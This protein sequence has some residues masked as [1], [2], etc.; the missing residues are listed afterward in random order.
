VKAGE[1]TF[2]ASQYKQTY[3]GGTDVEGGVLKAGT[4][5]SAQPFGL[6]N[7]NLLFN[8]SFDAGSIT[9][10]STYMYAFST[11][12]PE[13]PG[14][15]CDGKNVG[16][17]TANGTWVNT[18]YDIGKYAM[19]LRSNGA[20]ATIGPAHAEQTF[21]IA[22]PGQ[23][24]FSFT[25]MAVPANNRKGATLRAYLIH[26]GAT[27]MTVNLGAVTS[28]ARQSFSCR[29]EIAE[30]GEYTLQFYQDAGNKVLANSIDDVVFAPVLAKSSKF[31]PN[32]MTCLL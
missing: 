23:Y 19:Y 24:R 20:D 14:W 17:T 25:Y 26:G 16:L 22:D 8:G 21:R 15:T 18:G 13:N 6:C 1:G 4:F 27:N 9:N 2:I 32:S 29:V 10:G 28:A 3:A 11:K 12:W 30:A 7:D 5:G 31:S